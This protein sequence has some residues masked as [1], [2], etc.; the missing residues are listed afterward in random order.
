ML[1]GN[2]LHLNSYQSLI[3]LDNGICPGK[4]LHVQREN[5]MIIW[6]QGQVEN[7]RKMH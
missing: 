4:V 3:T 1:V 2:V 6:W 7:L 5:P